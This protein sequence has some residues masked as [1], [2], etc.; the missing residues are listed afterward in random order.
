MVCVSVAHIRP[1]ALSGS[2]QRHPPAHRVWSPLRGP[3]PGTASQ[4]AAGG[5]TPRC[6]PGPQPWT[7]Q[8]KAPTVPAITC[9]GSQR[10]QKKRHQVKARGMAVGRKEEMEK[11][12]DQKKSFYLKK[13][14]N[15]SCNAVNVPFSCATI[16]GKIKGNYTIWMYKSELMLGKLKE[17]Q[18]FPKRKRGRWQPKNN[19]PNNEWIS[20]HHFSI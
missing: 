5:P 19:L 12:G 14:R 1:A 6:E 16:K 15:I 17:K 9:R 20:Q 13:K 18:S 4:S 10:E 11:E 3:R 8:T 2:W 7:C